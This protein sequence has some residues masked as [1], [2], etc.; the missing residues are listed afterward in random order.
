MSKGLSKNQ[1]AILSLLGASTEFPC[2]V[3]AGRGARTTGELVDEL[4]EAE[5]LDSNSPRRQKLFTVWRA[6]VS[7]HRRGLIE[8]EYTIADPY[9]ST[10][11]CWKLVTK[12]SS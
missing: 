12:T 9:A 5:L 4:A 7:L 6:C 3:Y 8:G 10:T 2:Q 11:V 1:R